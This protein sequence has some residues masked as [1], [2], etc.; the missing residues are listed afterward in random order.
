MTETAT[1]R[2][3]RPRAVPAPWPGTGDPGLFGP[4]SVSWRVHADPLMAVG[5]LRALLMQSLHPVVAHG[6][7]AH[8]GYREQSWGR[9][10]RTAEYVA[11]T[12]FGSTAEAGAVA[13]HVRRAHA[14]SPFVDPGDGSRRRIDEPGLLLW[15]HACLV[16][17]MLEVT[18]RG[19]LALSDDEADG[20]VEEQVRAGALVGV[21]PDEAPRT[22][23]DVAAYLDRVRP[24]LRLSEPARDAVA[25]VLAPPIHPLLA[26]LTPARAGWSSLAGLAFATLPTWARDMFPA[27]LRGGAAV[28]PPAAVTSSLRSLR[29][30]GRGVGAL[31]PPLAQSPHEKQARR[32]LGL[33]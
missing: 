13:A 30:T 16:D 28:V 12:T 7:A 17:S 25:M 27:P 19:G 33:A 20:Y 32:R 14:G 15:V 21:D 22:R 26:L 1:A 29:L 18:R 24:G 6:F 10:M 4:G 23:A 2:R 8:S 31:V 3:P 5:G 11:L 9:L